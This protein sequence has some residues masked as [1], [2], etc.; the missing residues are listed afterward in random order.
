MADEA[1]KTASVHASSFHIGLKKKSWT[2]PVD[3]VGLLQLFKQM[4]NLF[5][6]RKYSGSKE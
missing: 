2:F 3:C 6:F 4:S 1:G 5:K